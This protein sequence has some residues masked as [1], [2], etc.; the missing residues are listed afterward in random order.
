MTKQE[1]RAYV[2]GLYMALS[3]LEDWIDTLSTPE[4]IEMFSLFHHHLK[5][6]IDVLTTDVVAQ[7]TINNP[8]LLLELEA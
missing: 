8:Q 6:Q 5:S 2:D 1:Q 7:T 3:S 4:Y